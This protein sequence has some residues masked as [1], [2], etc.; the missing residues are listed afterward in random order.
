LLRDKDNQQLQRAL[1]VDNDN[2]NVDIWLS[3]F[4]AARDNYRK[5][6]RRKHKKFHSALKFKSTEDKWNYYNRHIKAQKDHASASLKCIVKD[7]VTYDDS[8]GISEAFNDWLS[9]V[10][11]N[12]KFDIESCLNFNDSF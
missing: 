9:S 5:C 7:N 4:R 2:E 6:Y 12:E 11:Q 10:Q 1:R 8:A 3:N